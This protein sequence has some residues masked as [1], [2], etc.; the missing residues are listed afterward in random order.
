MSSVL[1]ENRDNLELIN[2]SVTNF[3][4]EKHIALF[5]EAVAFDHEA[6]IIFLKGEYTT[7]HKLL[8]QSHLKLR[9]LYYDLIKN[10]YEPKTEELLRNSAPVI[11][12]AKDKKAEYFL[13]EGFKHLSKGKE[14][15]LIGFNSNRFLY[16]TKINY[17]KQALTEIRLAKKYAILALTESLIPQVD[18]EDYIT[19]T[20][21]EAIGVT[22]IATIDNY[23]KIKFA[24]QNA[25]STNQ[26]SNI[27]P[28]LK[29]HDDNYNIVFGNQVS[30]LTKAISL[31]GAENK[32]SADK[33]PDKKTSP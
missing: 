20:L 19:Q 29:H 27:Y 22:E 12:M 8:R 26:L 24:L 17:Y 6:N 3:G 7:S 31:I 30:A 14:Y 23:Q 28:Y 25:I 5:N 32:E 16:T 13:T 9:D 10:S 21:N 33:A 2:V 18:K 11:F 1:P 4:T 15:R